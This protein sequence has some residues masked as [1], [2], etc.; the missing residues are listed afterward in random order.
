MTP[1][2]SPGPAAAATPS[3]RV[4]AAP[5][6]GHRLGDECVEHLDMGAR[7]DLRHHAAEGGMLADLGEHDIGQDLAAAVV[8][9]FH[10]RG[11]GLVAGRL[12]AEDNHESF[13]RSGASL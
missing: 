6:F 5:G 2:I 1:P 13:P 7:G 11:G 8:A 4:E 10:H 9:A 3:M 12:D